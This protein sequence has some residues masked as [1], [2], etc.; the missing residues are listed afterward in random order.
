VVLILVKLDAIVES[1]D[2]RLQ[3]AVA[4]FLELLVTRGL[5][6]DKE[7][8]Q[9]IVGPAIKRGFEEEIEGRIGRPGLR[10]ALEEAA[11]VARADAHQVL[12]EEFVAFLA[13]V[14]LN[15]KPDWYL[16]SIRGV[17]QALLA[18]PACTQGA[19]ELAQALRQV[20]SMQ[21]QRG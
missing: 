13:R 19:A 4:Q 8:Y 2:P 7:S 16:H 10:E 5:L 12:R 15:P 9:R 17:L 1:D 20:N 18:N 14:D 11:S 3:Y 21:T 6:L